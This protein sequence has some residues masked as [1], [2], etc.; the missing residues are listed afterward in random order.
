ML[1]VSSITCYAEEHEKEDIRAIS[2]NGKSFVAFDR[3][4][5]LFLLSLRVKYPKLQ[6]QLKNQN[7][8]IRLKDTRI[9]LLEKNIVNLNEQKDCLF[10]EVKGLKDELD[11]KNAWYRSPYL[12]FSVGVVL[13]IGT[14][15]A[16]VYGV[17]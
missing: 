2:I 3:S 17:S 14:T 12:W 11:R 13:G 5:A 9:D 1:I 4:S 16:V 15:I 7:H 8:L 6:L 10:E